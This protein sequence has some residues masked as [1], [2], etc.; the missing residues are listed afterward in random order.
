[1]GDGGWGWDDCF[2]DGAFSWVTE[3]SGTTE[4]LHTSENALKSTG[5]TL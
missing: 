3:C 1:M 2:W 5:H 4:V